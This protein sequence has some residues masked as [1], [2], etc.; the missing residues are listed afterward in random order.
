MAVYHVKMSSKHKKSKLKWL[1]S[2]MNFKLLHIGC[3]IAHAETEVWKKGLV[4][5]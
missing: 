3:P 5:I 1:A 4:M 2:G